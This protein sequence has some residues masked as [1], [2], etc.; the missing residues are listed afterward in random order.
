MVRGD[1]MKTAVA[2]WKLPRG[3]IYILPVVMVYHPLLLIWVGDTWNYIGLV[4]FMIL[5]AYQ[6]IRYKKQPPRK[7]T[8]LPGGVYESA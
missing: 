5:V 7:K 6:I 4:I 8:A 2:S 1:P 3:S